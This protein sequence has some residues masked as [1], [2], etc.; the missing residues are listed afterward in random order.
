MHSPI[1]VLPQFL[2]YLQHL[3][4]TDGIQIANLLEKNCS[5]PEQFI[6]SNFLNTVRAESSAAHDPE[7]FLAE[8]RTFMNPAGDGSLPCSLFSQEQYW[9]VALC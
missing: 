7:F 1:S 5:G 8:P 2:Q 4:L 9:N 3:H 6:V